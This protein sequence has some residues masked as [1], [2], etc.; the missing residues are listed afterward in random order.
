MQININHTIIDL[1]SK[2]PIYINRILYSSKVDTYD[3]YDFKGLS[4]KQ[5]SEL[6]FDLLY[7]D[8]CC[9]YYFDDK[10]NQEIDITNQALIF[11][12]ENN[13]FDFDIYDSIKLTQK[14]ANLW[15]KIFKPNWNYY[16]DIFYEDKDYINPISLE[17][18]SLNKEILHEIFQDFNQENIQ[19]E[20]LKDWEV[21]YWK[22]LKDIP[23]Y[24][25]SYLGKTL[26]E[27]VLIDEIWQN[28]STKYKTKFCEKSQYF[29]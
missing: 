23:I 28:L 16:I 21:C 26:D 18:I 27:K 7:N 3:C 17:L 11:Y 13:F 2:H 12:K 1:L 5:I 9:V 24:K 29:Y 19:I 6:I 15:E 10:I 25:Y 4:M 8:F 14:G 20:E 22:T